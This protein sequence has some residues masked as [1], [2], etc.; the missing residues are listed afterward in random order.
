[1]EKFQ[2]LQEQDGTLHLSPWNQIRKNLRYAL[3]TNAPIVRAYV[4]IVAL[5]LGVLI[6]LLGASLY[7]YIF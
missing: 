2:H 6:G 4:N 5:L 3:S 1:M 7:N